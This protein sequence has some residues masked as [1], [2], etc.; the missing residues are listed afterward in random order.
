MCTVGVH[1]CVQYGYRYTS[2]AI[3]PDGTPKP[4]NPDDIRIYEPS[5]WPGSPLPHAWIEDENRKRRPIKVQ[6]ALAK[7]GVSLT[8]LCRI[9]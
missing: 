7:F 5:T 3:L 9:L 4:E 6:F 1:G 8:V 2:A